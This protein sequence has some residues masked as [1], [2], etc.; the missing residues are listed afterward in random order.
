MAELG[1]SSLVKV[2]WVTYPDGEL[3]KLECN[4]KG[5]FIA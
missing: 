2:F 1:N 5:I 4:K 3:N